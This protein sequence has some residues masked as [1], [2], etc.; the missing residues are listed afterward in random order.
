MICGLLDEIR[1]IKTRSAL[2]NKIGLKRQF[3][4]T[5]SG[6]TLKS[7]ADADFHSRELFHVVFSTEFTVGN[8]LMPKEGMKVR[9]F[10]GLRKRKNNFSLFTGY[11]RHLPLF[12]P[13]PVSKLIS[14]WQLMLYI[15]SRTSLNTEISLESLTNVLV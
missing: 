1:C 12:M 2:I 3:C 10:A 14:L 8:H 4:K 9:D 7:H 6:T 15:F 11:L 13:L 5:G